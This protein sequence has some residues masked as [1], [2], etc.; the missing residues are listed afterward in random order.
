MLIG[1]AIFLRAI[2]SAAL[3]TVTLTTDFGYNMDKPLAH[4]PH[5][6]PGPH[7]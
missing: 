5:R 1:S 3:D 6:C 7:L 2:P 4:R